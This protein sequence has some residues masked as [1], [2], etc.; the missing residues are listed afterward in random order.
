MQTQL[1]LLNLE[2]CLG[3]R[4]DNSKV[5]V[6]GLGITGV[7]SLRYLDA[8]GYK[9]A[10]TDSRHAP[11]MQTQCSQEFP[12]VSI[13]TGGF[14]A[15]QFAEA[16][17]VLVSP[18]VALQH[19]LIQDALAR[20][21]NLISDIDLFVC[22]ITQ[23]L[24]AITGSNGKSTVTTML[25]EMFTTA[26]KKAA[27][28]GNL[29]IPALELLDENADYYVLE[30]SSFQLE[31]ARL[32]D[33]AAAVVLNV[34]PDHMD[35]YS[36]M[37]EY[38]QSK[39]NV[40]Q[41][42]GLMVINLDDPVVVQMREAD[43]DTLT[44]STRQH[45]DFHVLHDEQEYLAYHGEK[46]LSVS[47]LPLS[48]QHN[49]SNALAALAL[50]YALQV[51]KESMSK[52]LQNFRGLQHRMQIVA[53]VN[54]VVWI[55]DSKATNV[56]ACIAAL[57]GFKDRVILIAGGD[58]KGADM[59]LLAPVVKVKAKAVVL[60][61]KDAHLI[62]QVL[63]TSVEVYEADSLPKAVEL[64]AKLAVPGDH[65]LLSPACASLDQ[66]KNY[67]QRGDVFSQAVQGLAA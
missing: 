24:I 48:G 67:Q 41:G 15:T 22:S 23:P 1:L 58:A 18:G 25:G 62:A 14:T 37:Q 55:N 61:G 53:E 20:G 10:V 16:T 56:G 60:I 59:A 35:R 42:H 8:L 28:G 30:L 19:R 40:Y 51:D 38:I 4:I 65:V 17:H 54:G 50:G 39:R 44:Y 52:A 13:S 34:S 32:L 36:D 31:R 2:K 64:A 47:K 9:C 57:Q 33:A 27:V 3:L 63:P 49:I 43:R 21:C 66:F 26:G 46:I 45:A 7:S 12:E 5:L 11:E 6:V 29:G